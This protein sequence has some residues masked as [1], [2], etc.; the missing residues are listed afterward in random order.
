MDIERPEWLDD[1]LRWPDLDAVSAGHLFFIPPD[2][3][4]R[5]TP[6]ALQGAR[7]MCQYLDQAR[8]H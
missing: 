2:Y 5:H 3:L 6:R 7:Q 8:N 1:W 4:Q